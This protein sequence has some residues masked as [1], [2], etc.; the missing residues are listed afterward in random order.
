MDLFVYYDVNLKVFVIHQLI[1]FLV[2]FDEEHNHHDDFEFLINIFPV[3]Q[4]N[5]VSIPKL[6][7]IY[8]KHIS[9]K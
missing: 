8:T 4:E 5:I 2:Q 3:V 6:I 9:K 7:F 1:S